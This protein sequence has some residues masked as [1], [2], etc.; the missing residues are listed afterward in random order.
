MPVDTPA[1][2][3]SGL[4]DG[5]PLGRILGAA[6]ELVRRLNNGTPQQQALANL[7][8]DWPRTGRTTRLL[9]PDARAVYPTYL[10]PK[11]RT[12]WDDLTDQDQDQLWAECLDWGR[13]LVAGAA[14]LITRTRKGLAT[15]PI[16]THNRTNRD[17]P[18]LQPLW[19]LALTTAISSDD[20]L[21]SLGVG[22][23]AYFALPRQL[24]IAHTAFQHAATNPDPPLAALGAVAVGETLGELGR[25]VDAVAVYQD[26][27]D[28]FGDDPT[29]AVREHVAGALLNKGVALDRLDQPAD[30]VAAYDQVADRFGDDPTPAVREQVA[31]ALVNKGTVLGRL[32]GPADAVAAYDQVADRFGDDPT[33][34]V[35]EQVAKALYNKGVALGQL[36]GPADAVAAYDQVVDRFGD[37]PTPAR[38]RTGRQGAGQ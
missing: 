31:K 6:N 22:S 10:P 33:P 37:D 20:H 1:F 4:T 15:D 9:E 17:T 30:A 29:P 36:D 14:P 25:S 5:E 19:Q 38:A 32:D 16:H 24:D 34:A 8:A 11:D 27:V 28:R 2:V 12:A 35:R 26:L 13:Q 3:T 18:V 21:Q 7:V 23:A